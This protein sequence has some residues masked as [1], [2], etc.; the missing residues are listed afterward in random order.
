[1]RAS[2]TGAPADARRR[3][4]ESGVGERVQRLVEL[5]ELARDE[6]EALLLLGGAVQPLEL[7]RDP[8]EALEQ[9]VQLAIAEVLLL[10]GIDCRAVVAFQRLT[11]TAAVAARAPLVDLAIE[12]T[13]IEEI[14]RRIYE[15]GVDS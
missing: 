9:R 10:H 4:P 6:R 15:A 8:V 13:E 11:L 5:P 7:R 1:V 2:S 3:L 12:E 14:V